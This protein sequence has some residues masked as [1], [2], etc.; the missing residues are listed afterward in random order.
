MKEA[1]L[2]RATGIVL[3][4]IG[5]FAMIGWYAHIPLFISVYLGQPNIVFNSALGFFLLGTTFLLPE[6]KFS[7]YQKIYTGV[8]I[9]VALLAITT[10]SENMFNYSFGIDQFLVK[11]WLMDQ[12]PH[13]GRMADSS[14]LVFLFSGLALILLPYTNKKNIGMLVQICI[15]S[16]LILGFSL[17]TRGIS[18]RF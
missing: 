5:L 15:F 13:P 14:A 2:T 6:F 18:I 12:N 3:A 17:V 1:A 8:G 9:I 4:T 16:T 11:P 7:L 10:L